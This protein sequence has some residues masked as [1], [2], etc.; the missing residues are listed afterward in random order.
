MRCLASSF[1]T[2]LRSGIYRSAI[3]TKPRF[4]ILSVPVP[5]QCSSSSFSIR[6][7][8]HALLPGREHLVANSVVLLEDLVER[9][10]PDLVVVVLNA[11]RHM[12]K[13]VR[14]DL[15]RVGNLKTRLDEDSNGA[16]IGEVDQATHGL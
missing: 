8:H 14:E 9:L 10:L 15:D 1:A 13:F 3:A 5:D 7:L 11:D 6:V 16:I 4:A 2:T 12:S